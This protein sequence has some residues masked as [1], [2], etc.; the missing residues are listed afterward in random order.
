[1][2]NTLL[3]LG[4]VIHTLGVLFH[5]ALPRLADWQAALQCLS[6]TERADLYLFNVHVAYPLFVFAVVSLGFRRELTSTKL[7]RATTVLIAGFWYVRAANKVIWSPT[8]SLLIL[9]LC[10]AT[11]GLHTIVS[12]AT[13]RVLAGR[14]P[15]GRYYRGTRAGGS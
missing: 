14:S 15:A 3:L 4:G 10:I 13:A 2:V 12:G 9:A 7:G 5:A 1:M 8:P 11:A 6:A